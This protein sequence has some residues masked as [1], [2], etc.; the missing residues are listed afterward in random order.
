MQRHCEIGADIIGEGKTEL[1][2]LSRTVALQH[3]EKWDGTGYPKG[4]KNKEIHIYARIVAVADVFDA[5]I[6]KRPYKD[7]WPVDKAVENIIGES[8][9]QFDP[10]VVAAFKKA[11]PDII[12]TIQEIQLISYLFKRRAGDNSRNGIFFFSGLKCTDRMDAHFRLA[13]NVCW[14]RY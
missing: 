2:R 12:D 9:A 7:A 10:E 3:H 11:L 14:K 13:K 1:M 6:S 8:G 5:L 4:L